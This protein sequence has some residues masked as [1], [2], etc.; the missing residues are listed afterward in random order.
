[1]EDKDWPP[2]EIPIP[3]WASNCQI[4]HKSPWAKHCQY[5]RQYNITSVF[6]R[7]WEEL[8]NCECIC[9]KVN[10]P[11]FGEDATRGTTPKNPTVARL[12]KNK[13][14]RRLTRRIGERSP[15][16]STPGPSGNNNIGPFVP[17]S[18]IVATGIDIQDPTLSWDNPELSFVQGDDEATGFDTRDPTLS[19]GSSELSFMQGD[20]EAITRR[21]LNRRTLWSAEWEILM[22][23]FNGL[24][25]GNP[26]EA[27][28]EEDRAES[29]FDVDDLEDCI[30]E[31]REK[32]S[33][34]GRQIKRSE[35]GK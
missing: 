29:N 22:Q 24:W 11:P 27:G 20:D 6:P 18:V 30:A 13:H 25:Y 21:R 12:K 23:Q 26:A 32:Q 31:E 7:T 15:I 14:V 9:H 8:E 16:R 2:Q 34:R 35:E 17:L 33:E 4:P 10:R 28:A 1:M 19:N 5:C 3:T